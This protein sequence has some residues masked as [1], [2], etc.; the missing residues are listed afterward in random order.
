[1]Q[2]FRTLLMGMLALVTLGGQPVAAQPA[3]PFPPPSLSSHP[4]P[5]V[6]EHMQRGNYQACEARVLV[7][8]L[9]PP[10]SHDNPHCATRR[11]QPDDSLLAGTIAVNQYAPGP[12]LI[13]LVPDRTLR[14]GIE[15]PLIGGPPKSRYLDWSLFH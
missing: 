11:F 4:N 8:Q 1:M 13:A 6:Q 2:H 9:P 14:F 7:D 10:C 15:T 5:A 12:V 3:T